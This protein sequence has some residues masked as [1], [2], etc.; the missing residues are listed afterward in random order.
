MCPSLL[1]QPSCVVYSLGS[2]LNYR[3]EQDI[4]RRT[5]CRVVT[6][7]CT[8]DGSS[9]HPRHTFLKKC[10]GSAAA[11]A[12]NPAE[13]TT[14]QGVMKD[15]GHPA[16]TFLK[17]DIEGAEY[18]V[19]GGAFF[20][21]DKP[22]MPAMISMELHYDGV[23]YGTK[24]FKNPDAQG[25]LFWPLHGEVSVAEMALFMGHLGQLGYAVVSRDDNRLCPHCSEFTLLRV[26]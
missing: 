10:L 13:W 23:Y 21:E 25:T 14:L 2:K 20:G 19:L 11:A 3:F 1:A 9:I 5:P 16:I 18:D 6:F 7:D 15:L 26:E 22:S 12:A 8:V 24:V 17:I 4:L